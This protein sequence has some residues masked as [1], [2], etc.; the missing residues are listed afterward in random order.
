MVELWFLVLDF[1]VGV[2]GGVTDFVF[3]C[4][5]GGLVFFFFY[6]GSAGSVWGV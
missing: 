2:G 4:M 5:G 1:F 6:H 3:L